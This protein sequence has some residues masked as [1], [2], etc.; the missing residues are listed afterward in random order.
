[1]KHY[2]LYLSCM[3]LFLVS[4]IVYAH[5][6]GT[7]ANGGH[8]NHKTGEYH[9]HDSGGIEFF[10]VLLGI[11]ILFVVIQFLKESNGKRQGPPQHRSSRSQST[12]N[13]PQRSSTLPVNTP[14]LHSAPVSPIPRV[15]SQPFNYQARWWRERSEWYRNEKGWTCEECQICLES[16]PQYLHTH[17]I[18]GTQHNDPKYLKALCIG[19]HSEQPGNHGRLKQEPD[20][21]KFMRKYGQE[22]RLS[23]SK[24]DNVQWADNTVSHRH[25]LYPPQSNRSKKPNEVLL[26]KEKYQFEGKPLTSDIVE[27]I[28]FRC[29]EREDS[30]YFTIREWSEYVRT[31]HE[32]RGGLPMRGNLPNIVGTSLISLNRKGRARQK[33]SPRNS[34]GVW[35]IF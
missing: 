13:L 35:K 27:N 14:E 15:E 1:M 30:P 3:S 31:Y 28:L 9:S 26:S 21:H 24:R 11:V 34:S 17:H 29:S 7:D 20:Y 23:T 19:C 12:L 6:G 33:F 5:S 2:I 22:W 4:G 32:E 10:L 16:D 8:F 18:H 25:P